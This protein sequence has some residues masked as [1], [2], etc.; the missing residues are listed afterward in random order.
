M[1]WVGRRDQAFCERRQWLCG[2]MLLAV[3]AG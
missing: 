3:L 1:E 2:D